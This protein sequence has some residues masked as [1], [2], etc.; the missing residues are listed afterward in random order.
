MNN[1]LRIWADDWKHRELTACR[2]GRECRACESCTPF[3][4]DLAPVVFMCCECG[5]QMTTEGDG[6]CL[7]CALAK[8]VS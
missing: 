5:K 2:A 7:G 4:G 8:E 6:E 1:A 3:A